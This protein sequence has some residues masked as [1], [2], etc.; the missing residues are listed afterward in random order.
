MTIFIYYVGIKDLA[1]GYAPLDPDDKSMC[2]FEFIVSDHGEFP[3]LLYI[4]G[5]QTPPLCILPSFPSLIN[6]CNVADG[7]LVP[8]VPINIR[9]FLLGVNA[10]IASSFTPVP[11]LIP[12]DHSSRSEYKTLN[13][14]IFTSLSSLCCFV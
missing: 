5:L 2:R 8:N 7:K 6:L 10:D 1:Q 4:F 14:G 12:V 3:F 13:C 9:D 11:F